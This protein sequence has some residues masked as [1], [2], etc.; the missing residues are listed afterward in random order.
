L[1]DMWFSRSGRRRTTPGLRRLF[2]DWLQGGLASLLSARRR[3]V[4]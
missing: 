4:G 1:G 3:C 2:D